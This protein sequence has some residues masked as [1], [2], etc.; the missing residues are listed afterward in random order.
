[1]DSSRTLKLKQLNE[2]RL[3]LLLCQSSASLLKSVCVCVCVCRGVC[4]PECEAVRS[5]ISTA[6]LFPL[7]EAPGASLTS[8]VMSP[9]R[10]GYK[11]T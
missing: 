4:V 5:H 1:M 7:F 6:V 11:R 10:Q 3:F 8:G 9:L 2:L